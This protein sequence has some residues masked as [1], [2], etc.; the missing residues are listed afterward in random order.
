MIYRGPN[1]EGSSRD[2]FQGP[3]NGARKNLKMPKRFDPRGGVPEIN[4][5]R[6]TYGDGLVVLNS[7]SVQNKEIESFEF[8]NVFLAA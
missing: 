5:V 7:F 4:M 2:F 3:P 1:H 6:S 8:D